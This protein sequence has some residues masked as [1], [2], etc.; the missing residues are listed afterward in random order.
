M[1]H[2]HVLKPLIAFLNHS[3]KIS[4]TTVGFITT[5]KTLPSSCRPCWKLILPLA[6]T[7]TVSRRMESV[8]WPTLSHVLALPTLGVGANPTQTA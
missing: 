1:A 5:I 4:Y 2:I 7:D 8:D 3:H 6:E